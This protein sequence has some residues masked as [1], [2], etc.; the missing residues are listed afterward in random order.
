MLLFAIYYLQCK[1]ENDEF[2]TVHIKNCMCYYFY[3]IIKLKGFDF[4]NISI[5][6][7]SHGNALSYDISYETL[8]DP[9]PLCF[10]LDKIDGFIRTY[11][12]TRYLVLLS[13]KK[14]DTTY[15][16]IRYLIS[17]KSGVTFIFSHNFAK[18]KVDSYDS[19][20]REKILALH[21]VL[22]LIK[23]VLNKDKNHYYYMIFLE[24]CF[25]QL[26]EKYSSTCISFVLQKNL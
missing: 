26:A 16:R 9:K 23:S 2:K 22:L 10:R 24:K 5:D 17:L 21:N 13:P 3:D 20:P 1:I 4:D 7:K 12:G 19:L 8:M 14:Y 11:D 6:E 15:N 25:Y 18:T